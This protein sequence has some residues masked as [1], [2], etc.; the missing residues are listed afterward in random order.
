[1]EIADYI[2]DYPELTDPEFNNKI[3]HKKEFYDLRTTSKASPFGEPG[4]LWPHQELLSRFVSPYTT[5]NHQLL[6][7]TPGTGKTCGAIAVAEAS[8]Q[9][10]LTR[11]RILIIV[12]NDNLANQWKQQI[13]FVCTSG[14]Y[15]PENYF[16]TDPD[17]KLTE[18]E[19]TARLNKILKPDYHITTHEKMRKDIDGWNE[20]YINEYF[21]NMLIIIDEAHN[22]RIQTK[23]NKKNIEDS[24]G[25][26][27]AF[28][29]FLHAIENSKVLLLSGTPMFDR[30]TELPGLMN[31]ILPIDRQLPT[32]RKFTN[33]Y[34]EKEGN[35]RKLKNVKE[36]LSYLVGHVSYIRE[37]GN[38]PKRK[39]IGEPEW[40]T[41]LKTVNLE[42]SDTQLE[43]YLQAFADDIKKVPKTTKKGKSIQTRAGLWKNSRQAA[44]FVFEKDGKYSW[45]KTASV[46]LQQK[47]SKSL[48]LT[49]KG[50]NITMET[51]RIRDQYRKQLK[52]NLEMY[53]AKY[54]H[55]VEYVQNHP[56]DPIFIFTPIVSGAGGAIFLGNILELFGYSIAKGNEKTSNKR[57]AL[58][59]GDISSSVQRDALIQKFNSP[60][61]QNGELIQI[62]IGTQAISEGTSFTNVKHEF[63]VSPYWNNSG[64][65]QAVGRGLRANSLA[66]LSDKDRVVTVQELAITSD[67]LPEEQNI[68]AQMY[69]MSE[70]K[71]FEIKAAERVLKRAA[72]DCPLNYDRNVRIDDG[73]NSRSC[74]YQKCNYV[75]YQTKPIKTL[76]KWSYTLEED[77]LD[78]ST[79]LLYYSNPEMMKIVEKIKDTL[80]KYSFID[81]NGLNNSIPDLN[82]FKLLIL[83][84][85]YIIENHVTVYN[86]WGQPCYLRKEGNMLFLSDIPTEKDIL[87]SWYARYPYVNQIN[88][89]SDIIN[90]ELMAQDLKKLANL[91]LDKKVEATEIINSLD[92]NTQIFI[93]ER[94]IKMQDIDMTPDQEK[95]YNILLEMFENNLIT[96]EDGNI[97]IHNLEKLKVN[98]NKVKYVDF[99]KGEDGELRCYKNNSWNN[100][101]KK[102]TGTYSALWDEV[103]VDTDVVNNP[104]Q[105]Y[106]IITKNG[107]FKLADKSK[108][109]ETTTD[110]RKKYSGRVCTAGWWKLDLANIYLRVG[111]AIPGKIDKSVTSKKALRTGIVAKL[112]MKDSDT[113]KR[114]ILDET[115]K[116]A[117]IAD[118]QKI[119]TLIN[120]T[121]PELCTGLKTWFVEN[122]L[123]VYE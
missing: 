24:K 3:F 99:T 36:L 84:I 42:I 76:P 35:I 106:G 39:D 123:V 63:V 13:A 7:H 115:L 25:R 118:I 22:L 79:Y 73:D 85:E 116:N 26:Y 43:G 18:G 119:Y 103:N 92:L 90:D 101:P 82:S 33:K 121:V 94:L 17:K 45:G 80:R 47:N 86:R 78:R 111:A 81:I 104:Y 70:S 71:D 57:Y 97:V 95:L 55:I 32:G 64:T 19:K 67:N 37:G 23:T 91:D 51:Y 58:I 75:C 20:K 62:M 54:A 107:R 14:K 15:V 30:V 21:S 31:L 88:L 5:Y 72:W 96:V 12:P 16:S 112:N 66:T 1:M 4:D 56:T 52:E 48:K 27:N 100:C 77:Q 110:K 65:E 38:F 28:H 114:A 122:G 93:L 34:I 9:D 59:T 83:A 40:T 8:K 68:D 89:L 74:D 113:E 60:E 41:F 6:F 53:S 50:T 10:P 46:I 102:D 120:L 117:S 69:V 2:P 87:G 29:K 61:N 105:I 108:E 98:P 11:R 109:P 44:V 49:V